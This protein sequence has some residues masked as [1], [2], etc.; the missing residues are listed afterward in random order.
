M[1]GH[2]MGVPPSP[3]LADLG[4]AIAGRDGQEAHD[5]IRGMFQKP[6]ALSEK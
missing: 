1:L 2:G 6:G 3:P 5:I 4:A